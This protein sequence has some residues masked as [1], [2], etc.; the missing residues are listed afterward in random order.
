[1]YIPASDDPRKLSNGPKQVAADGRYFVQI[2]DVKLQTLNNGSQMDRFTLEVLSG[3]APTEIGKRASLTIFRD[4]RYPDGE[5]WS[6]LHKKLA[7]ATGFLQPGQ[8]VHFDPEKLIG[9]TF[10]A[11]ITYDGKY[12]NITS[13]GDDIWR[14]DCEEARTVPRP[15]APPAVA[16]SAALNTDVSDLF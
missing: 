10:V 8:S 3:T 1:M 4:E 9:R 5:P 6:D 11:Q 12:A 2:M 13:R 15:S 16:P 14:E 7:W